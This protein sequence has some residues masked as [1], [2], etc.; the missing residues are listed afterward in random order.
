MGTVG[1]QLLRIIDENSSY[2]KESY[3]VSVKVTSIFE[4]DG[5]LMNDKG[6]NLKQIRESKN[7]RSLA[8]W[9]PNLKA[10]DEI[11]KINAQVI[12]E[13]TPTN[14]KTGEPALS[15]ILLALKS[16]KHIISS[17]KG[18]FYLKYNEI[19]E[20]AQANQVTFGFESTVGSAIPCIAAKKTLAGN[21]IKKIVAIL[22]GTSNYILSRMTDEGINFDLAL[23]EAQELGYAEAD[24]TL[25]IKGYDAAGKLVILANHLMGWN[26]TIN[27]VKI[28]GIDMVNQD[29]IE[30]AEKDKKVIKH[31][32][33]AEDG[34]LEVSLK[35]LPENSPIAVDGTLNAI[36]L[37]TENAGDI[38][39]IGRGA[40]GSEAAAGIIAD[41]INISQEYHL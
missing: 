16:K 28:S 38:V 11:P 13:C 22:N 14:P 19:K 24:P 8:A 25:D 4:F 2:F 5:A 36:M 40:G 23:K 20:L 1:R 9:R 17:N 6:L 10:I 21:R 30:L 3:G 27:D 34:E 29:L 26:K 33:I 37:D 7:F 31:L 32:G 35:L 39:F 12:I 15:H 41:L 18:P